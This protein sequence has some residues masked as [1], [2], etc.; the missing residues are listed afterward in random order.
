M[1]L[2]G[3]VALVDVRG[4]GYEV[5]VTTAAAALL[6]ANPERAVLHTHLVVRDDAQQ[7]FGFAATAERD[8]FRI[9]IKVSGVGPRLG[10]AILSALTADE[11]SRTV[12]DADV[13]SMQRVPGIGKK[14]AQRLIMELRDK[15][16]APVVASAPVSNTEHDAVRALVAL[17][18]K[19]TEAAKVVGEI[20]TN[21]DSVEDTVREAL[22]RMGGAR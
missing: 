13:A 9:L 7:L 11:L 4:V 17:Q 3:E 18:Y 21:G 16:N 14:T 5:E 10:V 8:L 2:E 6:H 1:S 22:R 15:I 20:Y 12:A 19:E